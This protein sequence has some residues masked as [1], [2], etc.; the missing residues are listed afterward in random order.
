MEAWTGVMVAASQ[1]MPATPRSWKR[2]GTDSP[3]EPPEGA[4]PC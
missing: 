1:G 4:Q 3:S 2:Q